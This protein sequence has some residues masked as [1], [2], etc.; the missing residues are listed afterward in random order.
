MLFILVL[1][2]N[3]IRDIYFNFLRERRRKN[4]NKE[5]YSA[6]IIGTNG[7]MANAKIEYAIC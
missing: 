2:N 1:K 6:S 7:D 3:I 5:G 4:E